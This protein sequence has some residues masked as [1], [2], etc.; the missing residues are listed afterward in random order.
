MRGFLTRLRRDSAGVSAVEFALMAPILALLIAGTMEF[1]RLV[2]LT[3]KLQNGS[4][5]LA[6]L[7]ARDK[8]LNAGQLD[9]IFLA[10]GQIIQPF[11]F[12]ASGAAVVTSVG[13]DAGNKPVVNWQRRGAGT[14]ASPSAIGAQ[15]KPA[16]LPPDLTIAPGETIIVAEVF[17][18][19]EPIFGWT[20]Q[21]NT[22][23]KTAF[24]RPRLGTLTTL[25]P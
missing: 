15:G 9:T 4:F 18:D 23:R 19:Y 8:T 5:I 25:L 20:V 12:G 24:Y 13:T 22:I 14:L 17:Y 21:R 2:M 11:E 6:D 10:L 1:G 3:H 7:V 16:T